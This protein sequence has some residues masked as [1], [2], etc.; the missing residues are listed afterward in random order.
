MEIADC[1]PP[2]L[3]RLQKQRARALEWKH[4]INSRVIAERDARREKF[5]F[6]D[7][8]D[9][10]KLLPAHCIVN[11]NRTPLDFERGQYCDSSIHE[12]SS[13][14]E[15]SESE[16]DDE[17]IPQLIVS[18]PIQLAT[19]MKWDVPVPTLPI[20]P[21]IEYI[22]ASAVNMFGGGPSGYQSVMNIC[23]PYQ[24]Y[25]HS[26]LQIHNH[27]SPDTLPRDFQYVA[28]YYENFDKILQYIHVLQPTPR[29]RTIM[30]LQPKLAT[31]HLLYLRKYVTFLAT[32]PTDENLHRLN[33]ECGAIP[34]V[35]NH[36][37]LLLNP[38]EVMPP[39]YSAEIAH[40]DARHVALL[41]KALRREGFTSSMPRQ[42]QLN[43]SDNVVHR[44][45]ELAPVTLGRRRFRNMW[46]PF[47]NEEKRQL[48]LYDVGPV[49]KTPQG[50]RSIFQVE[51]SEIGEI[52]K[53]QAMYEAIYMPWDSS[54][55]D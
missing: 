21:I 25:R 47:S 44:L 17:A 2:V 24:L 53:H 28:Q 23:T 54:D 40:R 4:N 6:P 36:Q 3:T 41:I 16:S 37:G 27:V 7:G 15:A 20:V 13:S 8:M 50:Y 31:C 18:S 26:L 33:L 38:D 49:F 11:N 55:S 19:P 29:Y 42:A 10:L 30:A 52:V 46:N 45:G 12:T 48:S 22:T 32:I 35:Y 34:G 39:D 9:F 14:E 1:V 5:L 43:T 51:E